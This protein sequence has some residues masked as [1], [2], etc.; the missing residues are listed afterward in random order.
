MPSCW[1]LVDQRL[2]LTGKVP[3]CIGP[4]LIA[5]GLSPL[6]PV[7]WYTRIQFTYTLPPDAHLPTLQWLRR[8]IK[9]P[10]L[11]FPST[12]SFEDAFDLVGLGDF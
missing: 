6:A 9:W 3:R 7:T 10:P 8:G 1:I 2:A 5:T 4:A 11:P 12:V